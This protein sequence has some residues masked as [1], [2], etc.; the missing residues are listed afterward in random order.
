MATN[1]LAGVLLCLCQSYGCFVVADARHK[2]I[3]NIAE[4]HIVH[5]A[6]KSNCTGTP[7]FIVPVKNQSEYTV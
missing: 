6:C 5:C 7:D 4:V 2:E 3:L 1:P